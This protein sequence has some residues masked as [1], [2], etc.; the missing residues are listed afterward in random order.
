M[1]SGELR[2]YVTLERQTTTQNN[3]GEPIVTWIEFAPTYAKI[4]P[5]TGREY[6]SAKEKQNEVTTRI[7]IRF[8]DGVTE[9]MRVN[10]NGRIYEIDAVLNVDERNERIQIMCHE[11]RPA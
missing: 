9:D 8:V 10:H 1:K 2:H 6:F 5:L 3:I 4:E 7:T 11:A